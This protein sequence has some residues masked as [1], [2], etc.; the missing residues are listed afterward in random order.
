MQKTRKSAFVWYLVD[1]GDLCVALQHTRPR[2]RAVSFGS[3]TLNAGPQ[4]HVVFK[5]SRC[6]T[7]TLQSWPSV[8]SGTRVFT[9]FCKW[10]HMPSWPQPP[11]PT[12]SSDQILTHP[13]CDWMHS[14]LYLQLSTCCQI[15]RGSASSQVQ[16][17]PY[18]WRGRACESLQSVRMQSPWGPLKGKTRDY[19]QAVRGARLGEGG[20][21]GDVSAALHGF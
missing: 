18:R 17:G 9:L 7:C 15:T 6:A 14:H 5:C 2:G 13:L 8:R 10:G 11:P 21:G 1:L 20:E 16:T 12:P 3:S 4:F 19:T